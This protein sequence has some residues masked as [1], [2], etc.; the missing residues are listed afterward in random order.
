MIWVAIIVEAALRDWSDVGILLALQAINGSIGFFDT[1]QAANAVAAL[2]ASLKP[3]AQV[4][5]LIPSI[6]LTNA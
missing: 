5:E 6:L 3:Q 2:K 4:Q 1:V